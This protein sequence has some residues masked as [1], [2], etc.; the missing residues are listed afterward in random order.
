MQKLESV[1]AE[2]S[3]TDSQLE[4]WV[5]DVREWAEGEK[6]M[7]YLIYLLIAAHSF[8]CSKQLFSCRNSGR[9]YPCHYLA[10]CTSSTQN[11]ALSWERKCDMT[12]GEV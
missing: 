1:K 12:E 8:M 2:L 7:S 11:R 5:S 3:V 10:D 6:V 4:D 9:A